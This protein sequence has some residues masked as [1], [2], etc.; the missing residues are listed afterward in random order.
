MKRIMKKVALILTLVVILCVSYN[1]FSISA[2]ED[3]KNM[4]TKVIS[5]VNKIWT[6][7]FTSPADIDSLN[8]NIRIEDLTDGSIS[9]LSAS[10]GEDE[11]SVEINP[12]S[13]GYKLSHN[14]KLVIDKSSK[15]KKQENLPKSVVLYFNVASKENNGYTISA[16]VEVSPIIDI[17]KT[18]TIS[19]ANL[20]G[21]SKYKIEGS[22]NLC[23][24]GKSVFLFVAQDTVKVYL[25]DNKQNLLGTSTLD[26]STTKNNI[27]TD[28][29]LAD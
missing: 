20:P 8:N 23:D 26:V 4:G 18:I 17:A 28:I 5:N 25:Y 29:T 16:N 7:E 13:G 19:A 12:P 6:V 2:E 21:V 22:N 9:N 14:Y 15:S 3:F 24:I 1:T 27:S 10:Q 11:N